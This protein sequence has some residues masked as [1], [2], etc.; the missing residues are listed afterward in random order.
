VRGRGDIS[1]PRP[2]AFS[3]P[4]MRAVDG[5]CGGVEALDSVLHPVYNSVLAET[6]GI[7]VPALLFDNR[8]D[9]GSDISR[10]RS[11][12]QRRSFGRPS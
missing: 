12:L 7:A 11:R 10:V 6:G 3:G 5:W 9:V 1:R 8:I 2:A 4:F